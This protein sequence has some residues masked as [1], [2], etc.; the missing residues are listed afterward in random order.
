MFDLE[1]RHF[2]YNKTGNLSQTTALNQELADQFIRVSDLRRDII[3]EDSDKK[4]EGTTVAVGSDVL[5]WRSI[6][7]LKELTKVMHR[8]KKFHQVETVGSTYRLL[9]HDQIID[10]VIRKKGYQD[11]EDYDRR[12]L[13]RLKIEVKAGTTEILWGEKLGL[14]DQITNWPYYFLTAPYLFNYFLTRNYYAIAITLAST[15]GLVHPFQNWMRN[16]QFTR[17]QTLQRFFSGLM[18]DGRVFIPPKI[19]P[20]S[21]KQAFYPPLPIDKWIA[22]RRFLAQYG[23]GLIIPRS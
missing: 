15:L 22:G 21:W 3:I 10:D 17:L 12:Y 14:R 16:D 11:R 18:P 1:P 8:P 9:I 20:R 23:E 4:P 19:T 13:S 2:V 7:P 5:A 6:V